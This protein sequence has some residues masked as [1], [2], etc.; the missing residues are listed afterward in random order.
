LQFFRQIKAN[1]PETVFHGTDVGHQYKTTGK[2]YL[3][4]LKAAGKEGSAEFARAAEIIEQGKRYYKAL[5]PDYRENCMAA[6]FMWEF[7][8]LGESAEDFLNNLSLDTSEI[9]S[10]ELVVDEDAVVEDDPLSKILGQLLTWAKDHVTVKELRS[11]EE[12][13]THVIPLIEDAN[14]PTVYMLL[15]ATHGGSQID[16]MV[17]KLGDSWYDLG[18]LA[19]LTQDDADG[20]AISQ[21]QKDAM[22]ESMIEEL[23]YD[24]VTVFDSEGKLTTT[25]EGTSKIE[26]LPTAGLEN[27]LPVVEEATE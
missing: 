9:E 22:M 3:D 4:A 18:S 25:D 1:Y 16:H 12:N 14:M 23:I 13:D 11:W 10:P 15:Q 26:Q 8:K 20:G 27:I 5:Q 21:E 19:A 24:L 2:R 17:I 6:N 7:D